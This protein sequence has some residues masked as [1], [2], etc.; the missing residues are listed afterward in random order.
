V[1]GGKRK[2]CFFVN[3]ESAATARNCPR[4][5]ARGKFS[6]NRKQSAF[7]LAR[8]RGG[9]P[10]ENATPKTFGVAGSALFQ[11]AVYKIGYL[12]SGEVFERYPE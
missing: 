10:L 3:F 1:R 9:S 7:T 12:I 4:M 11:K 2:G 8:A 6:K 5:R